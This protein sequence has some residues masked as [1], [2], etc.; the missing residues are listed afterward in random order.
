[1][2]GIAIATLS[3]IVASGTSHAMTSATPADGVLDFGM[4]FTASI[5]SLT[6]GAIAFLV[7]L[8]AGARTLY[9]RADKAVEELRRLESLFDVLD[10]GIVVCSG[11]Q[12]VAVN[13]SFCRLLGVSNEEAETLLVSTFIHDPD[14]IDRLLS[15]QDIQLETE[16]HARESNT[17][18]PVEITARTVRYGGGMRRLLEIRDIHDRKET[19]ERVS[20]LAHHD[21]LTAL[22]NR[23]MLRARLG[24]AVERS[25]ES[26]KNCAVIWIDLDRFK[27]INDVHGHVMGDH[28]LRAVADKLRFE[29]PSGTLIARL[30]GD[31]FV[32]LCEEIQDAAEARLIGQHLRRLLNRPLAIGDISINVGASIGA[33][34]CPDDAASADDLLKNADLALYQA[35]SEGRGKCRHYT[36][37]L[38]RDRQRRLALTEQMRNAIDHGE[39]QAYFQPLVCARSLRVTGFE[40][41]GRWFHPE[42]GAIS[43]LEFVRLAEETGLVTPLADVILRQAID[44]ARHWPDDVRI[45]VNVSPVQINSELVDQLR[46]IITSSGFDPR[47]LE[48]EV[49]EDVLIKDFSQ[50]ASMF[51]RLRALGVQVAMDDFGAGYT[52]MGNLRRLNFER[53]KIDRIFAADLPGH[54]RSAAIVRAM[55]VLARELNLHV[56]VEGVEKPEQFLFL[57]D[58][59]CTE[60]QG[61]LFS[62]PKP[63]SAFIDPS[64]LQLSLPTVTPPRKTGLSAALIDIATLRSKRAS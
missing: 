16:L 31:E 37:A 30:G 1:V 57:R 2:L 21:P 64:T 45:S 52:S 62:T 13:T 14:V 46:S 8:F 60:V 23:E 42:F 56:T 4:L 5:V 35:K 61:F 11:M 32:V 17:P 53:I 22:P 34:V 20:F 51:A 59:G 47:R 38:S 28:I 19:Q 25:V 50:T 24:Q 48:L 43:P 18:I 44:A 15:D 55:L 36:E 40:A 3:E 7:S 58:E 63:F 49:T 27:E 26:G 9:R 41:L 6:G 39:I 33:A 54:R 29:L 12:I 10:E